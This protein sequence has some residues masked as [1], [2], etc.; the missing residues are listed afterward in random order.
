VAALTPIA[1]TR[2]SKY[3][4]FVHFGHQI[5]RER[6]CSVVLAHPGEEPLAHPRAH[7]VAVLALFRREQL[8]D[9]VK[10]NSVGRDRISKREDGGWNSWPVELA[11]VATK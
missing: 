1:V 8:F 7:H 11:S 3:E 10:I 2:R 6:A 4:P 9:V 5:H